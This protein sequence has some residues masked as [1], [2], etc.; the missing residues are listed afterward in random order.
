MLWYFG[1]YPCT[2]QSAIPSPLSKN[3]DSFPDFW[4]HLKVQ[5]LFDVLL[6]N[7]LLRSI[8]IVFPAFRLCAACD[9]VSAF[10]W[11]PTLQQNLRLCTNAEGAKDPDTSITMVTGTGYICPWSTEHTCAIQIKPIMLT[12]CHREGFFYL[13]SWLESNSISVH[14]LLS[15]RMNVF[16]HRCC[17]FA[18]VTFRTMQRMKP[19]PRYSYYSAAPPYCRENAEMVVVL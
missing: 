17:G 5:Y 19:N 10:L 14:F 3:N 1:Y 16:R 8:S 13:P 18:F 9:E 12:S 4:P 7:L 11:F 2:Y 6:P 15:F